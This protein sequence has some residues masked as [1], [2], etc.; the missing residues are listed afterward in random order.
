MA[1]FSFERRRRVVDGADAELELGGP[2]AGLPG[3]RDAE[4]ELGGPRAGYVEGGTR[5]P[6]IT[7]S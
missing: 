7:T 3:E 1:P 4:L 5:V 6:P 2:R